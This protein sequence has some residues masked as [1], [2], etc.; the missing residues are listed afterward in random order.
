MEIEHF[1]VVIRTRDFERSN[2]FYEDTLGFPCVR[3]WSHRDGRG[4]LFAAGPALIELQGRTED[5]KGRDEDYD[6][7]GPRHKITLALSV[8]SAEKAYEELRFRDKNIPGGLRTE[9]DGVMVFETHDPDG[10]R[11]QF[12]EEAN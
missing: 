3:N 5:V 6:Y 9:A 2:R 7:E 4:A 12:R 11:I 8:P 10:V 1:R